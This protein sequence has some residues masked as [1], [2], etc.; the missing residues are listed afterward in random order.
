M[1]DIRHYLDSTDGGY[2][3][4]ETHP[5][6]AF[7][8][9]VLLGIGSFWVVQGLWFVLKYG[10]AFSDAAGAIPADIPEAS[11]C[12]LIA[13]LRVLQGAA[14]GWVGLQ[15]WDMRRTYLYAIW[16]LG[17]L[18]YWYWASW[19]MDMDPEF[20]AQELV[21]DK[22]TSYPGGFC[23]F[24][25]F[26]GLGAV[27]IGSIFTAWAFRPSARDLHPGILAA[28]IAVS[29]GGLYVYL[30]PVPLSVRATGMLY[31]IGPLDDP[32]SGFGILKLVALSHEEMLCHETMDYLSD[33][34]VTLEET[35]R[36]VMYSAYDDRDGGE[37]LVRMIQQV[38][39][40]KEVECTEGGWYRVHKE[41][42]IWRCSVHGDRL[43]PEE[44]TMG[45]ADEGEYDDGG[46][47][48]SGDYD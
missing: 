20:R 3:K 46:G 5:F 12:W 32:R 26:L 45:P 48:F 39:G 11:T 43:P 23:L 29:V 47:D 38:A 41:T 19:I 37:R 15:A 22:L 30:E 44:R 18:Y 4:G 25:T 7:A 9:V 33:G 21:L 1:E 42:G 24:F 8:G 36:K 16:V 6:G 28:I 17:P 27:L 31:G 10:A 13:F 34:L 40:G 14:F 35:G 2:H